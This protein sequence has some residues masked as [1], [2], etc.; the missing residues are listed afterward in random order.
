[1][2]DVFGLPAAS[3]PY[4][5]AYCCGSGTPRTLNCPRQTPDRYVLELVFTMSCCYSLFSQFSLFITVFHCFSLLLTVFTVFTIFT[6]IH[7]FFIH[8]C[9]IAP[10]PK[11]SKQTNFILNTV[12]PPLISI[13]NC[14]FLSLFFCVNRITS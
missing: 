1:V 7:C 4:H 11:V 5:T 12:N 2:P 13:C 9:T 8:F 3:D 14:C 10:V 6:V